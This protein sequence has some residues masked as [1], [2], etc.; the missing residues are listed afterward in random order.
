M[1]RGKTGV[2]LIAARAGVPVLPCGI[3]YEGKLHFGTKVTVRY[4]KPISPE[5]LKISEKNESDE[6]MQSLRCS[7]IYVPDIKEVTEKYRKQ[8]AE[9]GIDKE[10]IEKYMPAAGA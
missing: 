9:L 5:Q 7:N 8:A 6:F 3:A 2:A 10:W 1:G 4:G